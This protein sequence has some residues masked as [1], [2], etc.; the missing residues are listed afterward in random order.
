MKG[1]LNKY[2]EYDVEL[3]EV[4][5]HIN[6]EVTDYYI[7]N[8]GIGPFEFQGQR[9]IDRG[10]N[11]LE[12]YEIGDVEVYSDR[13]VK[14][15][16]PSIEVQHKIKAILYSLDSLTKKIEEYIFESLENNNF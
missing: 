6:F 2:F 9:G 4:S 3:N 13:R 14:F 16:L 7:D 15:I 5:L 8:D 10:S 1:T 11:Y 12:S